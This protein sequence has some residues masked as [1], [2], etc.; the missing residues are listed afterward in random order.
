[1]RSERNADKFESAVA[2]GIGETERTNGDLGESHWSDSIAQYVTTAQG[3]R[4]FETNYN[5]SNRIARDCRG[6]AT[7]DFCGAGQ[8]DFNCVRALGKPCERNGSVQTGK[9]FA[10]F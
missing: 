2:V 6:G 10:K 7:V 3:C 1:M 9:T 4:R 8:F 5:L